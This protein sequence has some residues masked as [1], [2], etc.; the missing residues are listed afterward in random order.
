M[1]RPCLLVY[2]TPATGFT[3]VLA[4]P[5]DPDL[6]AFIDAELRDAYWWYV[7]LHSLSEITGRGAFNPRTDI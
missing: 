7:P 3:Y 2:G 4:T 5:N 6:E 1:T